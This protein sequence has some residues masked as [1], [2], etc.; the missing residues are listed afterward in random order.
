MSETH[1]KEP[2]NAEMHVLQ[3]LSAIEGVSVDELARFM[4][5]RSTSAKRRCYCSRFDC[6]DAG[7]ASG[8]DAAVA[9][10]IVCIGLAREV[11]GKRAIAGHQAPA[12]R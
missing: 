4:H 12:F 5:E 1:R 6:S 7:G 9:G 8:I 10:L 2:T 11:K 3:L